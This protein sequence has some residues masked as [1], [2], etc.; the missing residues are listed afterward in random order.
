MNAAFGRY[1]LLERLGQ[2][3]MA[4]VFKA[5]SYGVEGFEKILV[6]KR[7]LPELARS[8]DFV[9][10]FIHEA[11][12]AVRLSHANIVQVFDLGRTP[13]A[14]APATA[15][16]SVAYY[17]AMEYV[18]GLDLASFLARSR[19]QQLVLPIQLGVY[20]ASEVAKGLDHA[21]R[22]RDE[23]MRPLGI[24]HRDVSPQ[25]V[26]VSF[27]GEV[28][29]TDFG[30]AKAR[31]ALDAAAPEDT[32]ARK[33]QGKFGYMSPE[34]A[35]GESVDARSDLFS[36][37]TILYEC[38]SGV[39]PFS[40]PTTFETLRR[41]QACEYPPVELLRPDAPPEL[42]A[43]LKTAMAKNAADRYPDAGRMYEAL[44]AFLYAQGSR[45][46]AHDLAEF[47]ARFRDST[48]GPA[49]SLMPEPLLEADQGNPGT[50][51]TP[52]E[53]PSSRQASSVRIASGPRLAAIDRAVDMGERREV[54]ALV[55]ELPRDTATDVVG[56]A[57]TL[58]ERWGGRVL[59]REAGHIAAL[60]G[61][62]DPDG[63][64]TEMA[65]R[66]ALVAL[67]S[68]DAARPPGAGLH[69]GRIHVT[70]AGDP[71]EDDRLGALLDT[72]RDLARVRE[73]Q[74]AMSAQAMRPIKALFEFESLAEGDRQ[75]PNVA[76]IL[77]KDV[78]GPGEAFGRFV[79]R[80]D[81]L[82]RIG[83]VLALATK[84]AARVL[85]IRGDHGVGKTRLLHEV[86][87]R[88]RKGG[89]NVGFHIAACPPRGNEFPL[90]GV[91]SMI[92]VLCGTTE[93][94]TQER[95]LAVQPRLRALGL[96]GEE[97]NA[98]L[99]AIGATG[100]TFA[101]N[102]K[103]LL[104]TA[105]GRMVQSLCEDRPHTF[106]W[107]VAHSMDEET[108]ALLGATMD[109]LRTARLVFLFAGRA[110]FNHP[111]ETTPGHVGLE[112]GD[113]AAADVERLVALR[114][115][116]DAVP[117]ELLRFLRARAGGHPLFA[118]E[119][120]K[121]LVEVGAVTVGDRRVV[122]MKLV[123]QDL[124]L[125]KT[126]RGL[127]ASRVA[128]LSGEDRATLQAASILGDPIEVTALSAMLGQAMP[129]LERSIATLKDREFLVHTGPS[130]LRF[131]SPLIPEIVVDAL[132]HEAAREMHAAAGQAL[133]TSLGARAWEQAARIAEH[134][135]EAGDRER[136]ASYFAKSGEKRIEARQL[137]AAARDYARAIALADLSLRP[138]EE[139]AAWLDK[140]ASAVR[141]V[142]SAPDAVE[143][144]TRVIERVDAGG[145][146][147]VR[148][149]AR[150]AAG[151]LLAAAQ[152]MEESRQRLAEAEAIAEKDEQLAK[153]V[154]LAE[155][156]LATR[157]GDF[158]R[159]LE[160][161]DVL[162]GIVRAVSDDA[163]KHRVALHVA[164]A[165][166]GLG[167]R[168]TALA[169]LEEAEQ[170]LPN[171][172][173]AMLERTKVR[174]LVDYFTRDFRSAA[175]HSEKAIDVGREMGIGYEVML[176]LHNL[177]DILVHLDDLP[178]AYGA[179]RQSLAMCEEGGYE[180][181]ANYN[182][183]FLAFLDGIQGTVDGE[184]LLRHGIAYAV[185]K[186]FTWD[187]IGGRVLLAKLLQRGGQLEDARNEYEKTRALAIAAG[188][189]LVVD[190]CEIA[191]QRLEPTTPGTAA[192]Q[193]AS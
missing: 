102:S 158:K 50:E 18:H 53:V 66:C 108:F 132:T 24:V 76:G 44:L 45:F 143:L 142:R 177:G 189:R 67:R 179:I 15:D 69:T 152:H 166:A 154:L 25:N 31:G 54:T 109:R 134:L 123:G 93:G 84:R 124:A 120:I 178:R 27:E 99:S 28:K 148:V 11:K 2:G 65:T 125:P 100:P 34:Q 39:N 149:R 26:L 137:E 114:L 130:E 94:D 167:D 4:E 121:A 98:V 175:L 107:D 29:V 97:V 116:V 6:I 180:R 128:R 173:M 60:F 190:D 127:V 72:A 119:V 151:Q 140:L 126:L 77:V 163:E 3:G 62:G 52:V 105:F 41:V 106:A 162:H 70:A 71:T 111:M 138:P 156:E 47:L 164:Q 83:E 49:S 193:S 169:S 37:G 74:A 30:I 103:A 159:S 23:Q 46:G 19:R 104:R 13:A 113:L 9:E 12:L 168:R 191:L 64:D 22:R 95:I 59:R 174:A 184:K 133:E 96:Q 61:L 115:G 147:D 85:T 35:R 157:Q 81:E 42:V 101:G 144:C 79:G 89:Y 73:G 91:V 7:I 51:R 55:I 90:S 56:K 192:P 112:L 117:E 172:K 82:R 8:Q 139:P 176:N 40:A 92:Q 146:R 129:S 43:I 68:L 118:E 58:V 1:R 17:I 86:E 80:K 38:V 78:R 122:S 161:L 110:G 153:Q 63:R 188:H 181:L 36:L 170:V 87:R 16:P 141:M 5:K 75:A 20:V 21:H 160:R 150:V 57:A 183:M 171:D 182:R 33:L 48:D 185:S 131:A 155:A 10:M 88:L 136:A 165:N 32:R 145:S 187:V 135:Y 14:D 186:D